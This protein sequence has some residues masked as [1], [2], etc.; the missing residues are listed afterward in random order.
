MLKLKLQFGHLMQR[1]DLLEKTQCWERLKAGEEGDNR[2]WDGWMASLIQ[3]T[4][5]WA[6]VHELTRNWWT[7]GKPGV[8][9]SMGLR[10][11]GHDWA[12][13]QQQ[14]T[15]TQCGSHREWN[16][17]RIWRNTE[18]SIFYIIST[19]YCMQNCALDYFGKHYIYNPFSDS[20]TVRYSVC[21]VSFSHV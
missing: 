13:E 14:S 12:T 15:K 1:T 8:L 19:I 2:R 3:W 4:W 5:V 17:Q 10:R 6:R 16:I 7:T 21:S 11:A 18:V 20:Q 9:Q